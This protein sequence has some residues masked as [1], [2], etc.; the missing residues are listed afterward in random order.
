MIPQ[1]LNGRLSWVRVLPLLGIQPEAAVLPCTVPCPLKDCQGQ[2]TLYH[3]ENGGGAWSY[4]PG[5]RFAGDMIELA[6][7]YWD[8]LDIITVIRKL[9]SLGVDLPDDFTLPDGIARY[10]KFHVNKRSR[11]WNFWQQA[12]TR[13]LVDDNKV[14]RALQHKLNIR[15]SL[16]RERWLQGPGLFFGGSNKG[17]VEACFQ[18]IV[19]Q[20]YVDRSKNAGMHRIFIGAH[21]TDV[22]VIP[23]FDLPGKI[24]GFLFLG[25][26]GRIPED[27]IF[28]LLRYSGAYIF[29]KQWHN[30]RSLDSDC[31]LALYNAMPFAH[32]ELYVMADPILALRLQCWHMQDHSV[33][34]PVVSIYRDSKVRTNTHIWRHVRQPL[35]FWGAPSA[36]LFRHARETNALISMDGFT[37]TGPIRS[38]TRT[39]LLEHLKRVKETAKP[40]NVVLNSLLH[41]LPIAMTETIL[42]GMEMPR[43]ELRSY[44]DK[45]PDE[46]QARL[47]AYYKQTLVRTAISTGV[48]I[49]ENNGWY[50][51]Q[52]REQICNAILRIEQVIYHEKADKAYYSGKIIFQD[53]E[54]PFC[55]LSTEIEE[56]TFSWMRL[57]LLKAGIGLLEYEPKWEKQAV[58]IAL[59]FHTPVVVKG[60]NTMGWNKEHACF[61][62]PTFLI[63]SRGEVVEDQNIKVFKRRTP[64]ILLD[65]PT[66]LLAS[67]V[68]AL[69]K[70]PG[71]AVFWA[72][73]A[74]IATNLLAPVYQLPT[75]G[76][77]LLGDTAETTGKEAIR[78]L[79]C[80]EYSIRYGQQ[81]DDG[82]SASALCA[83]H[84]WPILLKAPKVRIDDWIDW[85]VNSEQ[86]NCILS[87]N[88]YTARSLAARD[89]WHI[90]EA[91]T[92]V[93]NIG[94][95]DAAR[96]VLP[97]FLQ[98]V[99][100]QQF[101]LPAKYGQI[102]GVSFAHV[103]LVMLSQWYAANGGDYKVVMNA[104]KVSN[105]DGGARRRKRTVEAF[106]DLLCRFF[107]DGELDLERAGFIT[108]GKAIRGLIVFP[109]DQG[110]LGKVFIPKLVVN[111]LLATHNAPT[112]VTTAISK[113][114]TAEG[115]AEDHV[116]AGLSGWLIDEAAWNKWLHQWREWHRH[117]LQIEG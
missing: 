88:W 34:A 48:I 89:G 114:L 54:V 39:P 31:G 70:G 95:C 86:K 23:F 40:W 15:L 67:T 102:D 69:P 66:E 77:G 14:L 4:C 10:L 108:S 74:C 42:L 98:Y 103:I 112:L 84:G 68:M 2:M 18:P 80:T 27:T 59:K 43:E 50:A 53:T 8:G 82:N 92:N 3:D 6:A 111:K 61:V 97:S 28:A 47:N 109:G 63:T 55:E 65:K 22:L 36:E 11:M 78:T 26:E 7:A 30:M 76:I 62:F 38:F 94:I 58:A 75:A 35:I 106:T 91:G 21:W 113:T 117:K 100:Q 44:I 73:T 1:S 25:R 56:G 19:S 64:G 72:L 60:F 104:L 33:P 107:D 13:L 71:S 29:D 9:T 101:R 52:D 57:Q 16:D 37:S 99:A 5:C 46:L 41:E 83:E 93:A 115:V 96:E 90:I 51:D 45:C 12:C 49:T 81:T 20:H 87:L 110:S 24:K 17:T 116:Y 32:H 105:F 85:L 79:G